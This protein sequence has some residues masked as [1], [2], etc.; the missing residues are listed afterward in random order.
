[1]ENISQVDV[2]VPF[3]Q[4]MKKQWSSDIHILEICKHDKNL[5]QITI[6]L[7]YQ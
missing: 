4:C 3:K 2:H 7:T 6:K 1:M 5:D